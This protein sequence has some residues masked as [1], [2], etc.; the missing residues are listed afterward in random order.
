MGI[1]AKV[2]NK[3]GG[4]SHSVRLWRDQSRIRLS[5]NHAGKPILLV[6]LIERFPGLG[7]LAEFASLAARE[8]EVPIDRLAEVK[9]WL[10]RTRGKSLEV[11]VASDLMNLRQITRLNEF[12]VKWVWEESAKRLRRVLPEG[13]EYAG[14]GWF[15]SRTGYWN[16][17]D[18][19]GDV[20]GWIKRQK[21]DGGDLTGFL[22]TA[23]PQYR[24]RN[25]AVEC[26]IAASDESA[27]SAQWTRIEANFADLAIDWKVNPTAICEIDGL[28]DRVLVAGTIRPGV[29]P[30]AIGITN[31]DTQQSLIKLQ[32]TRVPEFLTD[33]WP[34]VRTWA[35]PSPDLEKLHPIVGGPGS[36][37][38]RMTLETHDGVGE[39]KA[40]PLF[41]V[42]GVELL[43]QDALKSVDSRARFV[44]VNDRWIPVKVLIEGGVIRSLLQDN[45]VTTSVKL[46]PEEVLRRGSLRLDGPW[47]RVELPE[48]QIPNG[49]PEQVPLLH[50]EFLRRWGLPGGLKGPLLELE[51]PLKD[52]VE[53]FVREN[54]ESR[55]LV[56][57]AK[58]ALELLSK[59]WDSLSPI[60]YDGVARDPKFSKSRCG[61]TFT[62]PR[63]LETVPSLISA[64]WSV[65]CIIEADSLIKTNS[66]KL[67]ANLT[68]CSVAFRIGTFNS[69][70]FLDKRA[71]R[72]A[73]SE[74][75]GVAIYPD[76]RQIWNA[77]LRR[78]TDGARLPT[79]FQFSQPQP[80]RLASAVGVPR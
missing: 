71:Q 57:G 9:V 67:F 47:A 54:A 51:K 49:T 5:A 6:E 25:L 12:A 31:C 33:V 80:S 39:V 44:R 2:L 27:L 4:G 66:S 52:F 15:F 75:F 35:T 50:L 41:H 76:D 29:S 14:N 34:R 7:G 70:D 36:L 19:V 18:F 62:T 22:R 48:F 28:V 55:V 30:R 64:P 20:D 17:P 65:L 13:V 21:I 16:E 38:L 43:L 8:C 45:V 23:L 72:E 61:I 63:A 77:L 69:A 42:D 46:S 59:S 26:D 24:A 79:P 3:F 56:V 73:L 78:K 32:G 1:L 53:A 60:R 10:E 68:G 11:E 40:I 58:D 74:L 37:V